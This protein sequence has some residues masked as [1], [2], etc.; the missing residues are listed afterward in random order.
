VTSATAGAIAPTWVPATAGAIAPT[1]RARPTGREVAAQIIG[2]Q[3]LTQA[4]S[5]RL[6]DPVVESLTMAMKAVLPKG[7]S[8]SAL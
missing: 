3:A 4:V 2:R 6:G 5:D 8:T 7:T 1:S